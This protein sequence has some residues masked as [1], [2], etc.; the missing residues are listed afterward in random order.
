VLTEVAEQPGFGIEARW[1]GKIVRLGRLEWVGGTTDSAGDGRSELWL[2]IGS[3]TPVAFRLED[4]L[5]TDAAETIAGLKAR[6]LR[7]VLLSGDREQAVA[8]AA[9][10]VGIAE[11]RSGCLPG[12]KA[13]A[14][15]SL[16]A[17]GRQVLMVG[18]GINDAPALASANV[19]MSP[20]SAADIAQ[21]AAGLVFTGAKLGPV[22]T[23]VDTARAA[24]RK[25]R[26]NF[27]LAIAY[28]AITVPIAMAGLATPLIAAVAMSSSSIVVTANALLLPV[29]LKARRGLSRPPLEPALRER[30]A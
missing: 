4:A 15:A 6:G 28:N 8:P 10:R 5:R 7:V 18:D 27:A 16:R 21:T 2:R 17:A 3:A 22:L 30:P 19:S 29:L 13:E 23:A 26:Q 12:D 25:V 20:S 24:N 1:N 9:H 11:W 14:L